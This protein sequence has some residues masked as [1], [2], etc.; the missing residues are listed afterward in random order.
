MNVICLPRKIL[1][2]SRPR[3]L[4]RTKKTSKPPPPP[5]PPPPPKKKTKI[6]PR[7]RKNALF[8]HLWFRWRGLKFPFIYCR[9]KVFVRSRSNLNVQVLF[10]R[11]E[12][13]G[14]PAEKLLKAM[15]KNTNS[16]NI[17]CCKSHYGS[18]VLTLGLVMSISNNGGRRELS[19]LC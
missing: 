14:A 12:K 17:W 9:F 6:K 1:R 18:W 13:I 5:H 10:L 15:T 3:I 2:N 7:E 8:S 11:R 19:T 16:R 4:D